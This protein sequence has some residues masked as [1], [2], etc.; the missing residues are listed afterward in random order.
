[1]HWLNLIRP[2]SERASVAISSI[3]S[4]Q[5]SSGWEIGSN[6]L[7]RGLIVRC[8]AALVAL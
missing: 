8:R 5:Y 6:H 4:T 1:M 3:Q 7:A 2:H